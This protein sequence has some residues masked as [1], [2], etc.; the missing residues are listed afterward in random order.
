MRN[1]FGSSVNVTIF[2]ESHGEAIGALID[3]LPGG[4]KVDG[5]YI[6]EKLNL[7]KPSGK[8]STARVEKDGYK[9]LSGVYNG[10]TTGS[11]IAIIIENG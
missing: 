6:S 7:R 4:I 1:S 5:D 11:A 8:I 2:G 9:I 10:Y 3:G